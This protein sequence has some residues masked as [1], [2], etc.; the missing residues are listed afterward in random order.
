MYKPSR[1]VVQMPEAVKGKARVSIQNVL[2]ATD[3]SHAS[4][5]AITYALEI[6]GLYGARICVVHVKTGNGTRCRNKSPID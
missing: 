2:F 4:A 3:L 5:P 6:A 1:E